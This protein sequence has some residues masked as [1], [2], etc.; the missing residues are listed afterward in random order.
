MRL[1]DGLTPGADDFANPHFVYSSSCS[2]LYIS[3]FQCKITNSTFGQRWSCAQGRLGCTL[4]QCGSG[5]GLKSGGLGW[6][7]GNLVRG[8]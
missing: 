5:L 1:T 4:G 7:G 2:S 8:T 3:T 6:V